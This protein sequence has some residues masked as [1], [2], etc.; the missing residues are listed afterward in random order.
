MTA[1]FQYDPFKHMNEKLLHSLALLLPLLKVWAI[2]MASVT[3]VRIEWV[4]MADVFEAILKNLLLIASIIYTLYKIRDLS[5][6]A[7]SDAKGDKK[8]IV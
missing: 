4:M 3:L 5:K 7:K 8:D 1:K 2:N 6:K